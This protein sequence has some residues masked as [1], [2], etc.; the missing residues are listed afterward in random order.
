MLLL[1]GTLG[2]ILSLVLGCLV[3][4]LVGGLYY[5]LWWKKQRICGERMEENNIAHAKELLYLF[6]WNKSSCIHDLSSQDTVS[7]SS[8]ES[9]ESEFMRLHDLVCTPGF[10]F[11]IHEETREDS[12]SDDGKSM[13]DSSRKG[14]RARSL[15]DIV[16]TIETDTIRYPSPLPLKVSTA[17]LNRLD[18]YS[19]HGF[20]PLFESSMETGA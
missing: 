13:C 19:Q 6:C 5:P 20:N 11:T 18:S 17:A 9:V 3:L 8:K 2:I 14:S 16:L 10:L 12:E 1:S 15:S 4:A 7:V